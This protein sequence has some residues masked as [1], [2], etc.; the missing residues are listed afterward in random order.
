VPPHAHQAATQAEQDA[1]EN[2]QQHVAG[3]EED[4][5]AQRAADVVL[6][7]R[8]RGPAERERE[9]SAHQ[10][11]ERAL[12]QERP[13]HEPVAGADHA[14]DGDLARALQNGEP[15]GDADDDDGNRR[16]RGADQEADEAGQVAELVE[17]RD[18]VAPVAHVLHEFEAAQPLGDALDVPRVTVARLESDLERR[19]QRIHLEIAVGVAELD[20]VL[21]RPGERL[22]LAHVGD[23]GDFGEGGDVLGGEGDRLRRRAPQHERD[24]LHPLLHAAE[25]LAQ[26]H[27]D[28]PEQPDGEERKGDRGDGERREQRRA[29][30]GEQHLAE[31]QSHAF[32]SSTALSNTTPPS[33]SSM[34][35]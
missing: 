32:T 30:E 19:G 25:R 14:H 26:V 8:V 27:R 23:I 21:P 31:E 12:Q 20:Q 7:Q 10:T 3:I 16:E 11:L 17:P 28:E 22:I 33:R 34:V 4:Q 1:E 24:D 2:D 5:A 6:E 9:Q 18:P 35:R 29:A 15:D 13:A